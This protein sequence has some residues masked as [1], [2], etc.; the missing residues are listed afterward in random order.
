MS[1]VQENFSNAVAEIEN[2]K[3]ICELLSQTPHYKKMGIDGIYAIVA[4]ARSLNVNPMDAL[5]GGLYYVQGKVGMSSEMMAS[6]IR[7]RGHSIMKDAKSSNDICVLH[8]RRADNGDTWTV[9]FSMQ[10]ASRAGI[11]NAMY[12]KYPAI[13]LYNRALA[14]LARQLFPDVIKGAAY[15]M[16][17]LHEASAIKLQEYNKD[18]LSSKELSSKI[19]EEQTAEIEEIL[20]ECSI[21]YQEQVRSFVRKLSKEGTLDQLPIQYY[22]RLKKAALA[23]RE[24]AKNVINVQSE[25]ADTEVKSEPAQIAVGE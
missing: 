22:D 19:S 3:K 10:D 18:C 4:K 24:E 13:M 23:R 1:E 16:D 2:T 6:L 8:G 25:T 7:Q 21:E 9:S 11:A 20:C 12:G 15:T 17:E 14:I 5:N